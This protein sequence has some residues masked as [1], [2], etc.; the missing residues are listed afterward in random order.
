MS[1]Q[2]YRALKGFNTEIGERFE[3]GAEVDRADLTDG[4]LQELRNAEAILEIPTQMGEGS[5]EN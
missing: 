4:D 5:E 1:Q 3:P 2:K